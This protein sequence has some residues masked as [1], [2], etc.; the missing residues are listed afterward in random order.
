MVLEAQAEYLCEQYRHK[1][2]SPLHLQLQRYR[3]LYRIASQSIAF[4]LQYKVLR[5]FQLRFRQ[6]SDLPLKLYLK[7]LLLVNAGL[8]PRQSPEH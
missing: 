1:I 5:R 8:K 7:S 6:D 2:L 3:K 4:D